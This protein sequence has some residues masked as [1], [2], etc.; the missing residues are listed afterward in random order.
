M[1]LT[2]QGVF[3][4]TFDPIHCGHL[5]VAEYLFTHCPLAKIHFVPCLLPPHRQPPQASPQQRLAMV[6]LA[7]QDHPLWIADDI[8]LQR[9]GPS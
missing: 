7:I 5:A 9:P 6:R 1:P 2:L 8:D 3:G 4:G